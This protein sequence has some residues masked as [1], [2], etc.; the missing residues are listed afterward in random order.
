MIHHLVQYAKDND[1]TVEPGFAPKSIRWAVYCDAAGCFLDVV[2]LGDAGSKRNRGLRFGSCPELR[3]DELVSGSG[4]RCHFLVETAD[5]VALLGESAGTDRIR[6]KHDYFTKTLTE[7]ASD[8]PELKPIALCIANE[9]NLA[10]IRTRLEASGAKPVDKVMVTERGSFIVESSCWYDWWRRYRSSLAAGRAQSKGTK[11]SPD[12]MLDFLSGEFVRP[13]ATHPKIRGLAS[14]GGQPSGDVLVGF[15]KDAFRSFG[16]KKS[17]NAAM[18]EETANAYRAALND[19]IEKSGRR[20]AGAVVAHWFTDKALPPED[21][22]LPWLEEA[23]AEQELSARQ[24]ARELLASI[25]EGRRPDLAGNRYYALT[26][27]GAAGRVMVRDWMEGAFEEL[28]HNVTAWFDDL[29]IVHRQGCGK[30]AA[31]KFLAVLGATVRD[32]NDLPAPFAAKM[33]RVA[34]RGECIP[35]AAIS[36]ALGRFRIDIVDDRPFNHARMGLLRAYHVRNARKGENPTMSEDLRPF[37]NEA[38]PNPAYHCG[39][40]LAVLAAVQRRAL[41]D[42]GAGVIQRYYTAA[43]ATPALVLGRLTSTSQHHLNKLDAGLAR[44]FESKIADIWGRIEN[45]VPRI[46][47]L[48]EQSLFALGFYQQVA[49]MRSR[50][51]TADESVDARSTESQISE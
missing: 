45:S 2:E 50:K 51:V 16:L 31:P 39:R 21:D 5:V 24:R 17:A 46:L 8:V 40:L 38:H 36:R 18:S 43:S 13:A 48:E 34:V 26:L 12:L 28:V 14:V 15:D 37:L 27:S 33:W 6:V 42:V 32:L 20:L 25:R 19:I 41:G 1:L 3:Q 49:D 7:A 30:A 23:P 44:W 35:K 47:T 10:E 22:P 4:G 11:D 29:A 9:T